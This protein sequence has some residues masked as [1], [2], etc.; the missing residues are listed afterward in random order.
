MNKAEQILN[1]P[2][3][4]SELEANALA[5]GIIS[6]L[7]S[8]EKNVAVKALIQLGT[9]RTEG[10]SFSEDISN[11]IAEWLLT[12]YDSLS[13]EEKGCLIELIME[14]KSQAAV[15]LINKLIPLTENEH[16]KKSLYEAAAYAG[17]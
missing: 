10:V 13:N 3:D 17:T 14:L 1:N 9:Y 16:L 12:T 8:T 2:G 11:Q 5:F 15:K 7:E 6:E 4:V